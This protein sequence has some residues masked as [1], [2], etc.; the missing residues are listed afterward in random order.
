MI[1]QNKYDIFI[2]ELILSDSE[3]DIKNV[4][5]LTSLKSVLFKEEQYAEIKR[6]QTA[7]YI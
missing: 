7:K 4:F 5:E 3:L 2:T 1:E 6:N